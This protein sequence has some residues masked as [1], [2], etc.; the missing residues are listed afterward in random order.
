MI[1][2]Q[3][4]SD[5][6]S[7]KEAAPLRKQWYR[8]GTWRFLVFNALFVAVLFG[9]LRDLARMALKSDH[10][11]YI[12]FV[13]FISAYLVYINRQAIFSRKGSNPFVGLPAIGFGIL[14]LL[15]S[16]FQGYPRDH[17]DYLSLI[18]FSAILIWIGGFIFCFGITSFRSALFPLLFL[19]FAVPLPAVLLDGIILMLQRGSAEVANG[20]F[21]ATGL[22]VA[23]D[24]FIFIF[25]T[26]TI[27]VAQECSGIRSALSL[28]ITVS[29]AAHLFLRTISARVLLVVSAVPVAMLKNGMRIATL[30][31]LGAYVDKRI[32]AGDLHRQ[33][34]IPFFI[35]ALVME[36][37]LLLM[38]RKWECKRTAMPIES[39]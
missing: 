31:L 26:I 14:L 37:V 4:R 29:L 13:P 3:S 2:D 35:L 39:L 25:P 12:P 17:R 1:L 15:F 34:G 20:I 32:L 22:P 16:G 33:G 28:V 27:E 10:D 11:S 30:S 24:G 38:L 18:A 6:M 9:N 7:P 36:G 8:I 19:L 5:S 23:R 21:Y